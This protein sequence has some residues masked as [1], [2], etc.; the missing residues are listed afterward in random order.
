MS[1]QLNSPQTGSTILI[2]LVLKAMGIY[3]HTL[4]YQ[5]KRNIFWIS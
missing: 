2:Y 3:L 4:D 1:Q 5:N